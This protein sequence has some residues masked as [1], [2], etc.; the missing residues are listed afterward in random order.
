MFHTIIIVGNLGGDPELR[1]METGKAVCS[2]SVASSN[3]IKVDGETKKETTWW[4]V[5]VFGNSAEACNNHLHKGS[6]V[7]VEG[8]M[9]PDPETGCPHVY[10]KKDKTFGASY[11]VTA[12]TV[13]FLTGKEEEIP[14]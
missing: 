9:K 10:Q 14:F 8:R 4:R 3:T 7:L 13:K 1:Y 2:F 12:N 6:K 11:E 5:S